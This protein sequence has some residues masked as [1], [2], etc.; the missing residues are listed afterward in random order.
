M[1]IS[2]FRRLSPCLVLCLFWVMSGCNKTDSDGSAS[3]VRS[4]HTLGTRSGQRPASLYFT[5]AQ[6]GFVVGSELNNDGLFLH[7]FILKTTNGGAA[8]DVFSNDTLPNLFALFFTDSLTG[9]AAGSGTILKTINGG[10]KWTTVLKSG[11]LHLTSLSFPDKTHGYAVGLSGE[12]VKTIDGGKSWVTTTLSGECQLLSTC[13]ID[14]AN[15][16]VVG[17]NAQGGDQIGRIFK[18]TDGGSSWTTTRTEENV[19]L[20]SVTFPTQETGYAA[21]GCSI[22]KTTDAGKNWSVVYSSQMAGLTGLAF[23]PNSPVGFAIGQSGVIMQS[24]DAGYSWSS[25]PAIESNQGLIFLQLTDTKTGYA[26][27]FDPVAKS[28][29]LLKYY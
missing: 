3:M 10:R 25:L 19:Y 29:S 13:F 2:L 12:F 6:R 26:C 9:F 15:G 5:D 20:N 7:G 17:Y 18:T 28:G 21:G 16:Y 11:S 23:V 8:W 14:A 1:M 27:G 4:W 22:L 24:V